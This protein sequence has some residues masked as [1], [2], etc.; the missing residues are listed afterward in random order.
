MAYNLRWRRAVIVSVIC[1]VFF[2]IGAGYLSAHMLTMPITEEKFVELELMT[3]RQVENTQD[4]TPSTVPTPS[5]HRSQSTPLPAKTE[6]VTSDTAPSAIATTD[7]ASVVTTEA[8][9]VTSIS[10]SETTKGSG[11]PTGNSSSNTSNTGTKSNGNNVIR[12][13]ILNK[14]D[15]IYPQSARQAGIEGTVVLKIQIFETGRSGTISIS[16]SSENEQLDNAAIAAVRQCQ[17]V[18]AKDRNN[19]QA[20][21]CYTTIP[22]S[23]H[24]KS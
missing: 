22:I 12:P 4:S 21:A 14:V 7:T 3:E 9:T 19:G 16:R 23:F 17:F 15:P 18:P 20:V 11:E 13:S 24:L 10:G 6:Q 1:H 5:A 8:L 2:F